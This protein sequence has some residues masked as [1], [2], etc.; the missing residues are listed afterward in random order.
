MAFPNTWPPRVPSGTRSLRVYLTGTT[1]ALFSDNGFIFADVA[2][3]NPYTPLPYVAPGGERTTVA[4]PATPWGSGKDN[5][6]TNPDPA[7]GPI[8]APPPKMIWCRALLIRAGSG[9]AVE[10]SFDGTNVH[11]SVAASGERLY[12][13]RFEAGIALRGAGGTPTFT[14]EAW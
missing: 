5:H 11:G 14:I 12:F 2:N 13:D 1:T 6:D 7:A 3:A 4:V 10:F 8:I 9:G